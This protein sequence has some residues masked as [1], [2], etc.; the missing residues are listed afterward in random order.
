MARRKPGRPT[1]LTAM[2]RKLAPVPTRTYVEAWDREDPPVPYE[3]IAQRLKDMTGI[4]ITGQTVR[5][6]LRRWG[7]EEQ[8]ATEGSGGP[9]PFGEEVLA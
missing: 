2:D 9:T 3:V 1:A 4:E 8:A 5:N 6:W 7:E